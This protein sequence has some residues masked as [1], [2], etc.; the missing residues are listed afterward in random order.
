MVMGVYQATVYSALCFLL[1][2]RSL[3]LFQ[4]E[5]DFWAVAQQRTS[6]SGTSI[7]AFSRHVTVLSLQIKMIF[8]KKYK[9]CLK[10]TDR[11]KLP[12]FVFLVNN[13]KNDAG[14]LVY[15]VN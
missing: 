2:T 6:G 15:V 11:Q 10:Y 13:I 12:S 9:F 4:R 14:S 7:P 1:T 3:L 5:R 8:F